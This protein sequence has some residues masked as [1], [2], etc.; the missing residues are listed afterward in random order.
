MRWHESAYRWC[1]YAADLDDGSGNTDWTRSSLSAT[2]LCGYMTV[3]VGLV[4]TVKEL[5]ASAGANT[6][7]AMGITAL[8]GRSMWKTWLG[9]NTWTS[10]TIATESRE[11]KEIIERRRQGGDTEPSP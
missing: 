3:L 10:H 2:K 5:K 7:I 9:R 4:I 6:L 8:F 11:T 1:I